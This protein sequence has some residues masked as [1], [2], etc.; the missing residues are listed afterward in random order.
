MIYI[1][2]D[3][4]LMV[5]DVEKYGDV[6]LGCSKK[7]HP[8]CCDFFKNFGDYQNFKE[9]NLINDKNVIIMDKTGLLVG[10]PDHQKFDGLEFN[11]NEKLVFYVFDV[12]KDGFLLVEC[13]TELEKCYIF[14]NV[15]HAKLNVY[16][17]IPFV[18]I[19]G[20]LCVSC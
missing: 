20:G 19:W 13:K 16:D 17:D 2:E 7:L 15:Y 12:C 3:N 10:L 1:C 6:F 9:K 8:I 5:M 11:N 14:Q 4:F 18:L